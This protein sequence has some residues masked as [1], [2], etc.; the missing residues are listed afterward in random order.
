VQTDAAS[1]EYLLRLRAAAAQARPPPPPT[2]PRA[3]R[4]AACVRQI[5]EAEAL[6]G[7]Y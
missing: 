4:D 2:G 3:P 6:Y 5:A 1:A 7:I